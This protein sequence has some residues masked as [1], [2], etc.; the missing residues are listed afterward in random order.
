MS[1]MNKSN[2]YV[3]LYD[4]PICTLILNVFALEKS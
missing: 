3:R 1:D 2:I 4:I